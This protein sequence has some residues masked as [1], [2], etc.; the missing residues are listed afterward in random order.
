MNTPPPTQTE[1]KEQTQ[2]QTLDPHCENTDNKGWID[3]ESS[4]GTLPHWYLVTT[5]KQFTLRQPY[6]QPG[7]QGHV[8]VVLHGSL[9]PGGL[10]LQAILE[11]GAD[12]LPGA[13]FLVQQVQCAVCLLE[14]VN[15]QQ[16]L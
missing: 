9:I 1:D 13:A 15:R 2:D 14:S 12:Q 3:T 16:F 8:S 5:V 6:P 11:E 10:C 7:L 4:L